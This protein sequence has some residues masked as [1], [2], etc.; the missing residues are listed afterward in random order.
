MPGY[1]AA[2]VVQDFIMMW[3]DSIQQEEL[4]RTVD[5]THFQL[6][7]RG[8]FMTKD[9]DMIPQLLYF[10]EILAR[11]KQLP[12]FKSGCRDQREIDWILEPCTVSQHQQ[13]K[14]S[15]LHSRKELGAKMRRRSEIS[16]S[17]SV[18]HFTRYA[19]YPKNPTKIPFQKP[20][21]ESHKESN[22]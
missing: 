3:A 16:A 2:E 9:R 21:Y 20:H 12:M 17:N 14:Q 6:Q 11:Y 8:S 18:F 10:K 19:S 15:N 5:H 7:T 13:L 22:P 1:E 4:S